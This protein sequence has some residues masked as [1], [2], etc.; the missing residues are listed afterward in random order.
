[1]SG[2]PT[3]D[4]SASAS[5][6]ASASSSN[7]TSI[8]TGTG[9][10]TVFPL[11][12]PPILRFGV[13]LNTTPPVLSGGAAA[14]D[15][16]SGL[17]FVSGGF[18]DASL[19]A[20]S[21]KKASALDVLSGG[22]SSSSSSVPNNFTAPCQQ[23]LLVF[24]ERTSTWFRLEKP[25]PVG[26]CGH[27]LSF[28][29][30]ALWFVGGST[31]VYLPNPNT[32]PNMNQNPPPYNSQIWSLN[33]R[34]DQPNWVQSTPSTP[35]QRYN[36][37][38]EVDPLSGTIYVFGGETKWLAPVNSML[39]IRANPDG[40]ATS[41]SP[42]Y[43]YPDQPPRTQ[44]AATRI[45]SNFNHTIM[46]IY[47]G[48]T[49]ASTP[50]SLSLQPMSGPNSVF[51]FDMTN[52]TVASTY[53]AYFQPP[54]SDIQPPLY[55]Y[56]IPE[57][58]ITTAVTS[59]IPSTTSTSTTAIGP[60]PI[61]PSPAPITSPFPKKRRE[62]QNAGSAW[63]PT[64]SQWTPPPSP[65]PSLPS[66]PFSSLTN[67]TVMGP[68]LVDPTNCLNFALVGTPT[69][70]GAYYYGGGQTNTS[71]TNQFWYLNTS[72]DGMWYWTNMNIPAM[73]SW[74]GVAGFARELGE[75]DGNA[76]ELEFILPFEDSRKTGGLVKY[77]SGNRSVKVEWAG[78]L[79][80]SDYYTQQGELHF[81][82]LCWCNEMQFLIVG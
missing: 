73:P 81:F 62:P 74:W 79:N 22:S 82:F 68:C 26:L 16:I 36:H 53:I 14:R 58:T 72:I 17:L 66:T 61:L 2:Q 25:M 70:T 4:G 30:N 56:T 9:T 78:P 48:Y 57:P 40:T 51:A 8:G 38:A 19:F 43:L 31:S 77:F 65:Y 5:P 28:W 24:F 29:N 59:P 33:I 11:P 3:L 7:S 52:R 42:V 55:D 46:L 39:A 47:G 13:A 76:L 63:T 75:E 20:G 27:S 6:S 54:N 34:S 18:V 50:L 1:M 67:P 32:T 45:M 69:G 71:T 35:I 15:P 23:Q 64:I 49:T 37:V 44:A 60:H 80:I 10:G 21:T 41:L 12:L